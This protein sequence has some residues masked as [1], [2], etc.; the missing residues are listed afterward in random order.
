MRPVIGQEYQSWIMLVQNP[1]MWTLLCMDKIL[2]SFTSIFLTLF[3][4]L[5]YMYDFPFSE[6]ASDD[7]GGEVMLSQYAN[8]VL[9]FSSQYNSGRWEHDT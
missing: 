7:A 6:C 4:Y 3:N 9:R 8:R 2:P 5:I 1:N